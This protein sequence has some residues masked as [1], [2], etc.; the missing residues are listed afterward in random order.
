MQILRFYKVILWE[1]TRSLSHQEMFRLYRQK[2]GVEK[3]FTICKSDLKVSPVYLHQ[4][5]RIASMLLLNMVALLAYSLLER[6]IRQQGL[7]LTTRQIIKRL[8][9]LTLIETHCRDGS[10]LRRLTPIDPD[11][12]SILQLVAQV[13]DDLFTASVV[14]KMP[15][16]P[17]GSHW[18][19]PSFLSPSLPEVHL[20]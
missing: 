20:C 10:C 14:S 1:C 3:R 18:P 15:L 9:T 6:Q 16:L 7:Q 4:D 13:L 12:A 11:V 5:Q 19:P 2:D 8:E 17:T